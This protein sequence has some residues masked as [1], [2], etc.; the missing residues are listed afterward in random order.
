[1]KPVMTS[2]EAGWEGKLTQLK[3]MTQK[4]HNKMVSVINT[5]MYQLQRYMS[6]NKMLVRKMESGFNE[7]F[8]EFQNDFVS[9]RAIV[10]SLDQRSKK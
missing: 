5:K 1:M 6:E 8:K 4:L 2:S 10:E 9:L 7:T 3:R